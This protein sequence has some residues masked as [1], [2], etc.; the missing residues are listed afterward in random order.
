MLGNWFKLSGKR[1]EIFLAS[2]FGLTVEN[3]EFKIV[4]S[5]DYCKR[6]CDAS[7]K[8][9]GTD[10]IDLCGFLELMPGFLFIMNAEFKQI[11]PIVSIPR[12]QL[13]RRYE[14]WLN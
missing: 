9:L 5:G 3:G 8:R 4:S 6:A 14:R 12:H 7:L 11:M 2:K 1:D 10:S 13:K